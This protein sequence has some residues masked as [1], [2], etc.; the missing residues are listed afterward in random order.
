VETTEYVNVPSGNYEAV[1][2]TGAVFGSG[3]GVGG[4]DPLSAGAAWLYH[5]FQLG[6]LTKYN[7]DGSITGQFANR[8]LAAADLQKAIWWLEDENGG[9]SNAYYSKLIVDGS[10]FGNESA[11]KAANNWQYPVGI[12]NLWDVGHV[13]E[14]GYQHQDQLVCVPTPE[15]GTLLLVG[16]GLLGLGAKFRRRKK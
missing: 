13:G 16:A 5:Q 15:P 12:L 8:S 4:F 6:I 9:D 3:G 14:S 11:A 2:N 7:Y 10:H 1:L